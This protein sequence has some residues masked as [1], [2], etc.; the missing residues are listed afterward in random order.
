MLMLLCFASLLFQAALFFREDEKRRF[1]TL[2]ILLLNSCCIYIKLFGNGKA[3]FDSVTS[4]N[5]LYYHTFMDT[6]SEIY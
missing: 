3:R 4:V 5:S 1:V 2:L 6:S